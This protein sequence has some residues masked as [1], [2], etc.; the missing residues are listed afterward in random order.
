LRAVAYGWR[1]EQIAK[2]AQEISVLGRD[3]YERMRTLAGYV[4]GIGKGLNKAVDSYNGAVG[5][6]ESRVLPAARRF[7]D[8]R[9][10]SGADIETLTSVDKTSKSLTADELD[11]AGDIQG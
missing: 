11:N 1:Q 10:A 7:K 6:L 9:A 8:L 5:S 4:A 2:N 3:L